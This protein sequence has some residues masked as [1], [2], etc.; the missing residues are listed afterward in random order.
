MKVHNYSVRVL[1]GK[2]NPASETAEGYVPLEHNEQYSLLLRNFSN[3]D[4]LAKILVDGKEV[5]C[6]KVP[7]N[8]K[9]QVDSPFNSDKKFTFF[10]SDSEEAD[11]SGL[12]EIESDD[13]GIVEVKFIDAGNTET[14]QVTI[15]SYVYYVPVHWSYWYPFYRPVTMPFFRTYGDTFDYPVID[16]N[17]TVTSGTGGYVVNASNV[18]FGSTTTYTT[19]NADS[20]TLCSSFSSGGTG[21][22]GMAEHAPVDTDKLAPEF[23]KLFDNE[24]ATTIYLRLVHKPSDYKEKSVKMTGFSNKK[25]AAIN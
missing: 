10:K 2:N 15:G 19:S 4:A 13:L 21:L 23:N 17:L 12:Q 18:P 6:L 5:A 16:T 25:P 22:S 20:I 8:N 14:K 11:D 9:V 7:A 1:N 3:K 24:T